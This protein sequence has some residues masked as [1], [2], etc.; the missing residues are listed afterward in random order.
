VLP[1]GRQIKTNAHPMVQVTVQQ[2]VKE[3]RKLAR[4][5]NLSGASQAYHP[6]IP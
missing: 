6:A 2:Q 1:H 3:Q 5:V 4:F